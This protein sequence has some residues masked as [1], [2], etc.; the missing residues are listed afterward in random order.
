MRDLTEKQ[1]RI[2]EIIKRFIEKNGYSPT[3]REIMKKAKLN[4]PATIQNYINILKDK[5]YITNTENKNRTIRIKV[6]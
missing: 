6:E 2:Y 4:S 5:G 3:V 1:K